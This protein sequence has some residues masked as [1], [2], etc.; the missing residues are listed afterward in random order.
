MEYFA[1]LDVS[2]E[3]T[4]VCVVD[5][6]GAVIHQGKAAST[7]AD[8]E[9]ELAKAP[10][11]RRIVFETGRMAPMLFHG[12][13]AYGLPVVCVESRQASQALKSLSTH[14]T[15]RND[16][17]GLAHLARTGFFKPVHVKSLPAHAVRSLILARK[18]LVGQR[19][20][21]E[22]QIRGLAVVFGVRLPRALSPA[23]IEQ[24]LRSSEGIA[25][26][27]AAMRGLIGARAAVLAAVA[28]IDAD[29]KKMVRASDAC[30]RLMTIPGVGQLTAL[31]FTA[32]VDD[33]ERFRRSRDVG[34]YLGLVPRRYQSGEVDYTGSISKCGDRR[35][36]TLL[37]E[38]ANVMLTRCRRPLKLK[39]WALAIAQ[40]S[41]MRKAR[42]A[43]ARRLAIIMH[44][45]LRQG[46]EFKPA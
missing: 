24:A 31:A 35:V 29:I 27:S 33:P 40:R 15:D 28:A 42:I 45:M 19:V 13:A 3:E 2:M 23:F 17:R 21:L 36:R 46:T 12:L 22:N 39:D 14:K 5:R 44:A 26:L 4:H 6:D 16:A 38:A 10:A 7:P 41:T 18:K 9:Q 34:P 37:Y 20:T 8:I 43:L 32:A 25:G 30:R 1:G 11:C